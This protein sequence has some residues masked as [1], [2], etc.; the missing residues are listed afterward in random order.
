[1]GG[2]KMSDFLHTHDDFKSTGSRVVIW[3]TLLI[4]IV[5][6]VWAYSA[7][8]SQVTRAPGTIIPSSRTQVVQTQDGG[9]LETIEVKEG[10]I[11]EPGQLLAR[12]DSTRAQAGYLEARAK[13]AALSAKVARLTAEMQDSKPVFPSLVHEYHEI[14]S[15]ELVLLEKRNA[16]LTAEV[17]WLKVMKELAQKELAMNRPLLASGDVSRTEV[18]RLE[19]E[20]ADLS[21]RISHRQNRHFQEVQAELSETQQELESF[22]QNLS[23]RK[24]VLD[25]TEVYAPMRGIVKN[26]SIT[27]TGG[28]YRQGDVVME[29]VPL[30]DD[31]LVEAKVSPVDIAFLTLDYPASVKIDAYDYTIYGDLEGTLEFISADTV[32]D[33]LKHNEDPYFRV[34]VR[35]NGR[36]FRNAPEQDL[37]IQPGM[38]ATVEIMTGE[39][40][41]LEY[42]LKPLIK[43]FSEAMRER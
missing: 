2:D 35:T 15:N 21:S 18:L 38:T 39:R 10:D 36:S 37:E 29:I 23:Q 40:T 32:T 1:M 14:L 42:F 17:H 26:V 33:N 25:Q 6:F 3:G 11:V 27:T 41:V 31:L 12:I 24:S 8:L 34:R 28:V 5:F 30:E 43:T 7:K 20:V 13:V 9:V 4:I 19:R 22:A 16:A